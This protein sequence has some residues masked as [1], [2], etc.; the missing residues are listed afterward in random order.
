[1]QGSAGLAGLLLHGGTPGTPPPSSGQVAHRVTAIVIQTL[2]ANCHSLSCLEPAVP[3][4]AINLQ[5]GGARGRRQTWG[6][7]RHSFH[8]L[9]TVLE[10]QLPFS[11][12]EGTH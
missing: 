9:D 2:L 3:S 5:L 11:D 6:G 8:P 7:D 1:M 10:V 12:L 4:P